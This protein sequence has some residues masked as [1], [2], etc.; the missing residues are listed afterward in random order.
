VLAGA[1]GL[2]DRPTELSGGS[3]ELPGSAA[4]QTGATGPAGVSTGAS[5]L[6]GDVELSAGLPAFSRIA[7]ACVAT[8]AVTGTI[9][10]WREIGAVDA[11][12]S[13]RYGQLVLFKVVL[14]GALVVLGYFARKAVLR[15]GAGRPLLARLRKTLL[16][17]V[18]IGAVVLGATGVLISQPPGK[19]ALAAQLNKPRSS[20]VSVTATSRA[21]VEI[22]PAVHGSVRIGVQ[23]SAGLKPT[24]LSATASLPARQLG[25]I[26][27]VLQAAGGG[28]YTASNVLLPAAGNWQISLTVQT[29]EFDSTV[30]VATVKVS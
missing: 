20:T 2:P 17:E 14:F 22:D 4:E 29:S 9:Q 6:A 1:G 28:S 27:L 5:Q 21:V 13:T 7:M 18:L 30:A 19:V 11:I 26:P 24:N 12:T 3:T 15:R 8:L 23:L 10:A 25:P 16:S